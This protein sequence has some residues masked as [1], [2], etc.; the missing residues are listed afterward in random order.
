[1]GPDRAITDYSHLQVDRSAEV[2]AWAAMIP[3]LLGQVGTVYGYANNHFA[4]HGPATIRMLQERLDVPVVA[5]GRIG[6]QQSLF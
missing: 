2:D 1:M 6:E 3:V 5:P 4:G